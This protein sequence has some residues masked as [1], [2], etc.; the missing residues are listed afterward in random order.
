M[1]KGY[2]TMAMND[3][4]NNAKMVLADS[5]SRL[6]V[7]ALGVVAILALGIAYMKFRVSKLPPA[8]VGSNISAAVP[9][10]TSIPGVGQP[11][12]EY[13][14]LQEQQNE[15]LAREA[16]KKG[17][18][19][20]PTVVR[21]TY[22]DSS[23]STDLSD[24]SGATSLAGCS[25]EELKLA[26]GSGVSATELRCRGCSLAALKAAG[27]SAGE[28]KA[29]GFSAEELR[30]VGFSSEELRK[31]GFSVEELRKAGFSA[32]ELRKAGFSAGELHR[33]GFG[34]D[35]IRK[36]GYSEQELSKAGFTGIVN[37]SEV[38]GSCEVN[39]LAE[40]RA[41]GT[42]AT[43]L[44]KLG[45][46]ANA[47]RAA[48]FSAEELK[49]A[50]FS[51]GELKNAGF[52]INELR[53]VGF[54]ANDLKDAGF[55]AAELRVAGFNVKDLKAA[56]FNAGELKVAGF[57]V[58]D[59]KDAGFNAGELKY[60][61]F[62]AK[63]LVDADFTE[64][65]LRAAGY[66][67][68][69]IIRA[70]IAVEKPI[71]VNLCSIENLTKARAVGNNA[72]HLRKLGCSVA[73]LKAAG[74][75]VKELMDAGFSATELRAV[76]CTAQEL[77]AAG[78]GDE[79]LRIAGFSSEELTSAGFSNI[80]TKKSDSAIGALANEINLS[81]AGRLTREQI[82]LM[83]DGEY[84]ELLRQTQMAI[85]NQAN[86]LIQAWTPI[87]MQQYIQGEP[88]ATAVNNS[89]ANGISQDVSGA[90]NAVD[91]K[92]ND[93]YKAGGILLAILDT[94]VNSDENSPVMATIVQGDLKGSK[95]IGNFQ[96]TEKKVLIN[97]S[98]LSVPRL[99]SSM[100]IQAVAID[101]NTSKPPMASSV[102]NHY[103]LRYGTIL[104]SGFLTGFGEAFQNAGTTITVNS[105]SG[106]TT[107]VSDSASSIGAK[108]LAGVGTMAQQFNA[109]MA[110]TAAKIQPT[111]KV[112]AGVSI[113]ILLM[114]DL[115]VPKK[116]NK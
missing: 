70:G 69:D 41:R 73:A 115:I 98:V 91:T 96:R 58:K 1:L 30:E 75:T 37:R 77:A 83:N 62:T 71:S 24:Q 51:A 35:E 87:P 100:P 54:S 84:A 85:T 12:R 28:L 40:A 68:G 15:Q 55:S 81:G 97:F 60:A 76:G 88:K 90:S 56:G 61:G 94:E 109:T 101:P 3:K 4:L 93:I 31:A 23:V 34:A 11:T 108:S 86:Q 65:E 47:L 79:T 64:G 19:S 9:E 99:D 6:V 72:A 39:K 50:G 106:S 13:A 49:R 25:V 16:A 105:G 104:A 82:S 5:R 45:C 57:S 10:I 26:R 103:F 46:S 43:E 102:D 78:F 27:F 21:T 7:V 66:S 44:R 112:N 36:A 74:F 92:N 110:E 59:L 22:I 116:G 48:G 20:M 63:E 80:E 2:R 114:A 89:V 32:G 95:V 52:S 38:S 17:T 111:V 42:S 29:A 14:K 18:S 107:T 53:R 33:A 113:G 67:N 8:G